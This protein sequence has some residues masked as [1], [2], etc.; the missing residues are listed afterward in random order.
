AMS[1]GVPALGSRIGGIPEVLSPDFSSFLFSPGAAE[2]IAQLL[3][4]LKGWREKDPALGERCR[5]YV[6]GHFGMQEAINGIERV[7]LE[8]LDLFTRGVKMRAAHRV[9]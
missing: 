9:E 6:K 1:C 7:F 8:T 4:G 5:N 2:E 3:E